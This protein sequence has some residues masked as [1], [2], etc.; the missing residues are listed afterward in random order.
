MSGDPIT[1]PVAPGPMVI[2]VRN[3][4]KRFGAFVSVDDLRL[5]M[6]CMTHSSSTMEI[7]TISA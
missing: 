1:P 2:E 3:L 5:A 4:V 7:W 6:C